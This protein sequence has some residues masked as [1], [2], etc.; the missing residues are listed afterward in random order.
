[1]RSPG[2]RARAARLPR[3]SPATDLPHQRLSLD[4]TQALAT[5][6]GLLSGPRLGHGLCIRPTLVLSVTVLQAPCSVPCAE[7]SKAGEAKLGTYKAELWGKTQPAC[8]SHP[9]RDGSGSLCPLTDGWPAAGHLVLQ[10]E[11]ILV[12]WGRGIGDGA[13]VLHGEAA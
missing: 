10:V 11:G 2:W 5:A 13:Q 3:A 8:R 1:M 4:H 7:E 6:Q 9:S 12:G